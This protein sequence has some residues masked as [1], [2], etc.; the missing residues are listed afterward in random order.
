MVTETSLPHI[1]LLSSLHAA[2][3]LFCVSPH[4][5]ILCTISADIWDNVR[6]LKI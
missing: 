6:C 4:L 2:I 1:K 5:N 3:T